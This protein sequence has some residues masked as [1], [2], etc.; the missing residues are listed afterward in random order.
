MC[1]LRENIKFLKKNLIWNDPLFKNCMYTVIE[2]CT[3]VT[4]VHLHVTDP[5][6]GR[7]RANRHTD[8]LLKPLITVPHVP[9]INPTQLTSRVITTD[10][11]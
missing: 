6:I 5:C 8:Q 2:N 7:F 9:L 10:M 11:Q 1:K 4:I 3:A